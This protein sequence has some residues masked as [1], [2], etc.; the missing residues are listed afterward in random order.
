[1]ELEPEIVLLPGERIVSVQRLELGAADDEAA[2][3]RSPSPVRSLER[4]IARPQLTPADRALLAAFSGVLPR[5]AWKRSVLVT[6]GTVL[7]WHRKLVARRWTYPH[8]GPGR[9]ATGAELRELVVRLAREN[10]VGGTGGSRASWSD[11]V[12]SWPGAAS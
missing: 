8:R 4:Q 2:G 11:W 5:A 10:K 6:P 9:P 3:S 1:M 12:S 7:R